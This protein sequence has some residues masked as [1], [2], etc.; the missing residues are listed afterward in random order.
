VNHPGRVR[1]SDGKS[2]PGR[3]AL[4]RQRS[5]SEYRVHPE[6]LQ[7]LQPA[8]HHAS[9][10]SCT[11]AEPRTPGRPPKPPSATSPSPRRQQVFAK[12]PGLWKPRETNGLRGVPPFV[13][14][15]VISHDPEPVSSR[16]IHLWSTKRLRTGMP[17]PAG[18]NARQPTRATRPG[19]GKTDGCP[20]AEFACDGTPSGGMHVTSEWR[21]RRPLPPFQGVGF[22][23]VVGG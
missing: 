19:Q 22:Q 10:P 15:P 9:V 21:P 14:L 23:H 2:E 1:S 17:R 8:Q 16:F 12:L 11:V 20:T 6:A 4:R 5:A 13:L 18:A 7:G 3:S